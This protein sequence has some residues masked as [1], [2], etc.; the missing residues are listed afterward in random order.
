MSLFAIKLLALGA[1][2]ADHVGALFFPDIPLFRVIGRLAL[3]LFAWGIANGYRYTSNPLRYSFR[4]L[5]VAVVSQVPFVWF[6]LLLGRSIELLNILF[7]LA[8]GVLCMEIY[9][10]GRMYPKTRW[11]LIG[12]I[13]VLAGAFHLEYGVYAILMMLLFHIHIKDR[14]A[15]VYT[16]ILLVVCLTSLSLGL[17]GTWL[18]GIARDFYLAIPFIQYGALLALIP[19]GLYNEKKGPALQS[20]FYILYPLHLVLLCLCFVWWQG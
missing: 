15:I 5:V 11:I 10:R 20:V 17:R 14:F 1:M 9:E 18:W 8:L 6:S 7:P 12:L 13:A 4:L 19:I 16:Q 3:P 2:I